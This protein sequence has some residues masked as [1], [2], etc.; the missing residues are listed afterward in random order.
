MERGNPAAV[1]APRAR[2]R[3]LLTQLTDL[4]EQSEVL[5]PLSGGHYELKNAVEEVLALK[6]E[7]GDAIAISDALNNVGWEALVRGDFD[8]AVSNL[9]E[10][11]ATARDLGDTFRITL[12]LCNLG[13][14]AVLQGRNEE[15]LGQLR[16]A[17]LLCIRR[18]DIRCGFETVL[19]LAAALARLGE[20]ELSVQLDAIR[21]GG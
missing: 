5:L 18:G 8:S 11:V 1:E 15:A 16:E 10:A 14:A 9:E 3:A 19:G 13:L 12:A 2:S 17:L 7:A 21:R 20:D 4:W 6:R